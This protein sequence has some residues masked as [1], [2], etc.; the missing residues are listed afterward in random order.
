MKQILFAVAVIAACQASGLNAF[1]AAPS[2]E[3]VHAPFSDNDV[4][5]FQNPPRLYK[6]GTLV[7]YLGGNTSNEGVT[8][9]LEGIKAGGI[10]EVL[11]FHGEMGGHWSKIE[12][13]IPCLSPKWYDLIRHT[14]KE[15][16]RL[17]LRLSMLNCPGWAMSGGPWVK[18]ENAMRHLAFS[19]QTYSVLAGQVLPLTIPKPAGSDYRDI[20]VLAFPTPLGEDKIV[21][22]AD[23]TNV[24]GEGNVPPANG[25]PSAANWKNLL[26][27]NKALSLPPGTYAFDVHFAEPQIIRTIEFPSIERLN[28]GFAYEPGVYIKADAVWEDGM[29]CAAN[30]EFPQSCWQDGANFTVALNEP[31]QPVKT[32]RITLTTQ[33]QTNWTRWHFITAAKQNN[34]EG[35][36]ARTL[37]GHVRE[38]DHPKQN[39]KCYIPFNEITDA[40]QY[41]D[42]K[43][44]TLDVSRE[45]LALL[46][47]ADKPA[48]ANWTLLRIGHVYTG[49]QN[50]PAPPEGRGPE[51]DKLDPKG[52]QLVWDNFI[53]K[54]IAKDAPL[55]GV[56][57]GVHLDSW[58]CGK[59]TWTEKMPLYFQERNKY[60]VIKYLPAC[61]GYVINDPEYT[62][63]FLCDW[64][65]TISGL[66]VKNYY[67]KFA[68]LAHQH[69]LT[70]TFE[71]SGGDVFPADIMEYYKFADVPMTEFWQPKNDNSGYVGSI[72]FKPLK[73]AASGTRLYGKTRLSAEALTSFTLTWD[74][75]FG[76]LKDVCDQA[77]VDG[78]SHIMFHTYT[79]HPTT[80]FLPPGT[81]FGAG[82]GT[83]FLR[84]QTW[85]KFM[86]E[87]C[88][89]LARCNYMLER[90]KPVSD[91]LWYLGDEVSHKPNQ[92]IEFAGYKYDYCNP[93][94]LLHRLTAVRSGSSTAVL[95][96]P[97]GLTYQVLYIPDSVRMRLDTLEKIAEFSKAGVPI[98]GNA[99]KNIA[100]L[101]GD[102]KKFDDIVSQI[103]SQGGFVPLPNAG[104]SAAI[105]FTKHIE[106][107]LMGSVVW[108]HRQSKDVHWYFICPK[109]NECFKGT[110][111]VRGEYNAEIWDAV[112]GE[113]VPLAVRYENDRTRTTFDLDLAHG[114]SCFIVFRKDHGICKVNRNLLINNPVILPEKEIQ[115]WTLTFPQDW[116]IGEPLMLK[117]L[118]PWKDL[119]VSPEG[120]AFSGTATYTTKFNS[121]PQTAGTKT[122]LDLGQVNMVAEVHI[123]G[124]KVRTLWCEPYSCDITKFIKDGEND[125]RIDVTSTWFNRLVY[126]AGQPEEKRKTWTIAGPSQDAPLKATGLLGPVKITAQ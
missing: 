109:T 107:D 11:L 8:A 56:L 108:Q 67:G 36:A 28:H 92:K 85:W 72:N 75:H 74:E 102:K 47:V 77:F 26:M 70:T 48:T 88:D 29:S 105:N 111:S 53:G 122:V 94:V 4:K 39:P 25:K 71:T 114:E 55:D 84:K 69:G 112:S 9:D 79:L 78:V 22:P 3:T 16:K 33:H 30:I 76:M 45:G 57:E 2:S 83:P 61:L 62:S 32:Y 49:A 17:G 5:M 54:L 7:Y 18:P 104:L 14:G 63:Q 37:R 95:Q 21:E 115:D 58:E 43:T 1:D 91:I 51:C 6:P 42:Y 116:G 120:K 66:V 113:T 15:C 119:D 31:P 64:R 19:R 27:Q 86:P 118:K 87:F 24:S 101:N 35:E 12:D 100:G 99:P 126:D 98:I 81:S 103:V 121:P 117:K 34:W 123:N 13:P 110:I 46:N 41:F 80:D 97:E 10:E 90:G 89:Y 125:L 106:P 124:Q 23:V 68:E 52:I 40:T 44:D 60:D 50:G 59:Q 96:T 20:C 38:A 93:D 65:N 82:I 73:P